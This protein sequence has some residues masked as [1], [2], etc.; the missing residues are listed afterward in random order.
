MIVVQ[1][2]IGCCAVDVGASQHCVDPHW[3]SDNSWRMEQADTET[4][5][6]PRISWLDSLVDCCAVEGGT[7]QDSDD[8]HELADKFWRMEQADTETGASPRTAWLDSLD[9]EPPYD[10]GV[11]S[12]FASTR[13]GTTGVEY[14]DAVV[15]GNDVHAVDS[16]D[17]VSLV[18]DT[19]MSYDRWSNQGEAYGSRRHCAASWPG[20]LGDCDSQVITPLEY[21]K[22]LGESRAKDYRLLGSPGHVTGA[23]AARQTLK[24]HWRLDASSLDNVEVEWKLGESH[25]HLVDKVLLHSPTVPARMQQAVMPV[26]LVPGSGQGAFED[27]CTSWLWPGCP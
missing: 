20:E 5:A 4:G 3:L 8:P 22:G 2:Y 25:K 26:F 6:S 10:D 17:E 19:A 16:I 13:G 27:L 14:A 11:S 24:W 12:T 18:V 15:I 23:K 21:D 1:A 9:D 7:L